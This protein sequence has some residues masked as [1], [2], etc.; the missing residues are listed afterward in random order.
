MNADDSDNSRLG[1]QRPCRLLLERYIEEL[2]TDYLGFYEWAERLHYNLWHI[3]SFV[4]LMAGFGAS[5]LAAFIKEGEFSGYA[6]YCLIGLPLISSGISAFLGQFRT[7]EME[8]V[9]EC[10]RIKMDH[11]IRLATGEMA[12]ATTEE[13]C[14]TIYVNL[15]NTVTRLEKEQHEAHCATITP[16]LNK[17]ELPRTLEDKDK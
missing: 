12:A 7:R 10:G 4:S 6:K 11:I 5:I 14:H 1:E 2:K 3:L 9:R 16:T 13:E 17:G 15:C 8:D